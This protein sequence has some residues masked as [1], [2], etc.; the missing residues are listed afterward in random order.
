MN[1]II[2]DAIKNGVEDVNL[3]T[4]DD[5]QILNDDKQTLI[6]E[7][8]P[9]DSLGILIFVTTVESCLKPSMPQINLVDSLMTTENSVHFETIGALKRYLYSI[10]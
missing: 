6:G 8:A 10:A 3:Q 1:A 7:D 5:G 2:E 9:L 4:D